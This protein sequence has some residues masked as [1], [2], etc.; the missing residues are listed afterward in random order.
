MTEKHPIVEL[1]RAFKFG[2]FSAARLR[3][4]LAGSVAPPK[5]RIQIARVQLLVR[6]AS[7]V[8]PQEGIIPAIPGAIRS[9]FA[10]RLV[11]D[12]GSQHPQ[13]VEFCGAHPATF[14]GTEGLRYEGASEELRV[15]VQG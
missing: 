13:S 8:A 6:V 14:S 10:V 15:E 9:A 2:A 11:A 5:G 12:S 1:S 7:V 3:H 4:V